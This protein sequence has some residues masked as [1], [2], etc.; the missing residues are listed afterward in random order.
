MEAQKMEAV[1]LYWLNLAKL[2]LPT[3]PFLC[4]SWAWPLKKGV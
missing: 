4:G 1:I 3:F 2:R